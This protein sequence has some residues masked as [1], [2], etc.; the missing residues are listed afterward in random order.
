MRNY[1]HYETRTDSHCHCR[2][3]W[4]ACLKRPPDR[5]PFV[6][7]RNSHFSAAEDYRGN[8][9]SGRFSFFLLLWRVFSS[10]YTREDWNWKSPASRS[11]TFPWLLLVLYSVSWV[12]KEGGGTHIQQQTN[13][14]FLAAVVVVVVSLVVQK[15]RGVLLSHHRSWW[16][17]PSGAKPKPTPSHANTFHQSTTTAVA[18]YL[19]TIFFFLELMSFKHTQTR[20]SMGRNKTTRRKEEKKW[21]PSRCHGHGTFHGLCTRPRRPGPEGDENLIH[22]RLVLS[23]SSFHKMIDYSPASALLLRLWLVSA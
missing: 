16:E 23:I 1:R 18:V 13:N 19:L 20:K 6:C 11:P 15:S 7:C 4:L 9:S 2:C 21:F 22:R 8:W 5:S 14:S 12:L 3:H 10:R 17:A